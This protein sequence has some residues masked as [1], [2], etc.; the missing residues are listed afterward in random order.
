MRRKIGA[1]SQSTR[2][3]CDE[4]RTKVDRHRMSRQQKEA[5]EGI[6]GAPEEVHEGRLSGDMENWTRGDMRNWTPSD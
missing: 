5:Y 3:Q 2:D 6:E 4:I 1:D